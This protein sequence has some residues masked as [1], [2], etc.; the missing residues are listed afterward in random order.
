MTP[1]DFTHAHEMEPPETV[2]ELFQ[3]AGWFRGRREELNEVEPHHPATAVLAAF[4]GLE[5]R[6]DGVEGRSCA[7]SS[8]RFVAFTATGLA[9]DWSRVLETE[10]VGIAELDDGH[11]SLY[12]A[13]DGRVF[14]MSDVHDAF[15]FEGATFFVAIEHLLLGERAKPMLHPDQRETTLY[16][17][18]HRRG[19]PAL[20]S[21][22]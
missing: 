11:G 4:G 21:W 3:R 20:Y 2:H 17:V 6:P 1:I 8:V 12:V 13:A 9:R 18:V 7:P 19:D 14:G 22:G 16:G 15:F 10:L 5:I